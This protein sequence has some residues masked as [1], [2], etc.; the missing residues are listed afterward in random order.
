M[1]PCR[2]FMFYQGVWKFEPDNPPLVKT[3]ESGEWGESWFESLEHF[4]ADPTEAHEITAAEAER[5]WVE[6]K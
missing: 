6:N 4:L 3:P 5:L 1:N 2:Y